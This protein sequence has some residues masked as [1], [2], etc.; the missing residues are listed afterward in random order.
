VVNDL[1]VV[2][3]LL[4][5]LDLRLNPSQTRFTHHR[6][7]LHCSDTLFFYSRCNGLSVHFLA[8]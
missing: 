3:D 6:V 7:L 2:N 1:K 8:R 4:L 5:L